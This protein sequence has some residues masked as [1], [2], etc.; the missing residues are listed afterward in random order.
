MRLPL[1]ALAVAGITL[2]FVPARADIY[3]FTVDHCTGGCG[4]GSN[5]GTVSVTQNGVNDVLIQVALQGNEKFVATGFPG[6]F[7]FNIQAISGGNADN[8]TVQIQ[9][10]TSGWSPNN[11]SLAANPGQYDGFGDLEY[12]LACTACGN[13]GS[14]P[15]PPPLSF[16]VIGTGLTP[17]SF[18]ELSTGNAHVN[19]VADIGNTVNGVFN[20]GPVGATLTGRDPLPTPEPS[21][22][23][24]LGS[25]SILLAGLFK[26]KFAR[27]A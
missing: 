7:A 13:G 9:N 10:L 12:S 3:T 26:K 18:A 16:D 14:S 4:I 19:F 23:V 24:L 21:S 5:G 20:T 15:L 25:G 1:A 6:S 17:A 8:P 11:S 27:R 2:A 22:I